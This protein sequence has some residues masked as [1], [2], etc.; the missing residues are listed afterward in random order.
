MNHDLLAA[1][2]ANFSRWMDA[3]E[4]LV[5]G[6]DVDRT[7]ITIWDEKGNIKSHGPSPQMKISEKAVRE[8]QRLAIE[9]GL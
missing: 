8:M 3:E 2:C 1:Y 7:V 9:L 4:W 6:G 5:A